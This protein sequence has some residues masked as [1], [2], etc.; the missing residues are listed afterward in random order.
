[1]ETATEKIFENSELIIFRN[2][3]KLFSPFKLNTIDSENFNSEEF[4]KEL[5]RFLES[6]DSR[7]KLRFIFSE[8]GGTCFDGKCSR[9]SIIDNPNLVTKDLFLI[10]EEDRLGLLDS[11]KQKG[12]KSRYQSFLQQIPVQELKAIFLNLKKTDF[13]EIDS[14]FTENQDFNLT[15]DYLYSLGEK[16]GVLKLNELSDYSL[17]LDSFS[18]LKQKI[19]IDFSIVTTLQVRSKSTTELFLRHKKRKLENLNSFSGLIKKRD[20]EETL[21]GV[22]LNNQRIVDFEMFLIVKSSLT[23]NDFLKKLREIKTILKEIGK[24][25]QETFGLVPCLRATKVCSDFHLPLKDIS[26]NIAPYL[27][28]YSLGDG[29]NLETTTSVNSLVLQRK[30]QSL[31]EIDLFNPNYS[32]YSFVIIGQ[33]GSGK[34][35]LTGLILEALTKS[36][37]IEILIVDVGGSHTNTVNQ[38][39]GAIKKLSLSDPSGIN[40]FE[41]IK[42]GSISTEHKVSILSGFVENLVLEDDEKKL[43]QEEKSKIEESISLY[44]ETKPTN[45]TFNDYLKKVPN[46]PRRKT[47][48]RFGEKG[49]FKNAFMSSGTTDESPNLIYYNFDQIFQANDK[50]FSKAGLTAVMTYFSLSLIKNPDKKKLLIIDECPFFIDESYNFFKLMASNVRKFGGA[51]CLIA[52]CISHLT[53]NGDDKLVSQFPNK[54]LFSVDGEKDDFMRYASISPY[55][56]EKVKKLYRKKRV[57]SEVFFKDQFSSKTFTIELTSDEYWRFTTDHQDK[58]RIN[59]LCRLLPSFSKDESLRLISYLE[60]N[61]TLEGGL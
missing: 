48:D 12:S 3:L 4:K 2:N 52:Q 9:P 35:V 33:T 54:F 60:S 32:S 58:V 26:A 16:V 53:P 14:L 7:V 59:E 28:I 47:L 24:F 25:E 29:T 27:P 61:N 51:I 15:K 40:P 56:Y 34:S 50:S 20:N 8:R 31:S 22:E 55:E 57:L 43:N 41:F 37:N 19:N 45:P 13:T 38:L 39:G 42:D 44:I 1:M 6:L 23:E 10:F 49:I 30:D 36:P 5:S 17:E 21:A 11:F 18:F 46:V